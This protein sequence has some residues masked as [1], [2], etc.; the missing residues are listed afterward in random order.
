MNWMYVCKL[1]NSSRYTVILGY[2]GTLYKRNLFIRENWLDSPNF[3]W[4]V[5]YKKNLMYLKGKFYD[6]NTI[7][8]SIFKINK[9]TLRLELME[10]EDVKSSIPKIHMN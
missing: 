1:G 4:R 10:L 9:N 7:S 2:K 6:K 3:V 8:Q 5:G